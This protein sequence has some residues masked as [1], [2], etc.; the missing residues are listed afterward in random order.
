MIE[1]L[2]I[3]LATYEEYEDLSINIEEQRINV[4]I[5]KAQELDLEPFLGDVFYFDFIEAVK[6]DGSGN[7][8]TDQTADPTT[9]K[10]WV[11]LLEGCIYQGRDGKSR[12]FKG[13]KPALVYWA[14]AR[15][16]EADS[17]HY[18]A[19]GPVIKHRD[20][21]D[22]LKISDT[23]KLVQQ[24]RSVANAYANKAIAFL[25]SRRDVYPDW[26]YNER[27][28]NSRQPG[29]RIR[30]VDATQVRA[31]NRYYGGYL[32]TLEGLL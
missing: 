31:Q 1:N 12:R 13:L 28:T 9:P 22:N 5:Q 19:T 21:S 27:N 16:I 29:P 4:F 20:Q 15:Y 8:I 7:V 25:D 2:L 24:Q 11:D 17:V 6:F 32:G 14:F 26:R 3:N 10:I 23:V 30:S 18:T